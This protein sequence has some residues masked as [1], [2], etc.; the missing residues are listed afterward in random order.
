MKDLHNI[1]AG[2]YKK[3]KQLLSEKRKIVVTTHKNPDGDAMGS[4][5]GMYLYLK[6]TGHDVSIITPNEYPDFLS[7]LPGEKEI[8]KYNLHKDIAKKLL[9]DAEIIFCLDYNDFE[10]LQ[11]MS[12]AV[13]SLNKIFVL[14]DHHPY[15]KIK[16]DFLFSATEVSSTAEL[17]FDTLVNIG[18][19][20]YLDKAIAECLYTGIMTDTGSFSYSCSFSGTFRVVTELLKQGI[21]MDKIHTLVYDNFSESRMRLLG[22]CLNNRMKVFPEFKTAYIFLTAEDLKLYKYKPGDEEGIVNYPLSIK[23]IVFSGIFIEKKENVKISFR[24]RGTFPVNEF[25]KLHFEG[26]GH[27]NAAG[28][29]SEENFEECI[30]RF[31]NLLPQYKKALTSEVHE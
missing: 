14:I 1:P 10:R 27:L 28:G 23:G 17:I 26:G 19:I 24:S 29:K 31:E 25:S 7:W 30:K 16:T 3:L 2:R 6:K 22:Y 4:A 9:N 12:K 20:K 8:I 5:L 18:G 13:A 21:N 15:P 11:Q